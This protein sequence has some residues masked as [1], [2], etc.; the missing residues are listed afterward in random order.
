MN[1]P[2]A[3]SKKRAIARATEQANLHRCLHKP[4]Q[5]EELIETIKSGL[6]KL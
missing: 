2:I 5:A 6:M 1:T 3:L 4:W